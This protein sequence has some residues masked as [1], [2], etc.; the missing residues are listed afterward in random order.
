[1]NALAHKGTLIKLTRRTHIDE[2]AGKVR[3]NNSLATLLS[4]LQT[5]DFY[6]NEKLYLKTLNPKKTQRGTLYCKCSFYWWISARFLQLWVNMSAL[7]RSG[8][9]GYRVQLITDGSI[10]LYAYI[11]FYVIISPVQPEVWT[12]Q[13]AA[14]PRFCHMLPPCFHR[15]WKF[16]ALR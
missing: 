15:G 2:N 3:E 10:T 5:E 16:V 11:T 12:H 8:W 1:M 7:L 14:K 9:L 6:F 13:V 4:M